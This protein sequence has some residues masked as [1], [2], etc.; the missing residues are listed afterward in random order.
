MAENQDQNQ[1]Q[2]PR[3]H[4][5]H[6][7]ARSVDPASVPAGEK[8]DLGAAKETHD[9]LGRQ[10]QGL[11]DAAAGS[12]GSGGSA[13]DLVTGSG[14]GFVQI[15]LPDGRTVTLAQPQA[16]TAFI[17]ARILGPQDCQNSIAVGYAKALM[18]VAEVDG[19]AVRQPTAMAEMQALANE[20]GDYNVDLILQVFA[21]NWPQGVDLPVLKKNL[22]G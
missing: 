7:Q 15:K 12:S 19:R 1:G 18:Y 16:A 10:L 17:I 3:T 13:A 9:Q 20:L 2:Q 4:G 14:R 22:P 5:V 6:R 11:V 21:Q 8:I